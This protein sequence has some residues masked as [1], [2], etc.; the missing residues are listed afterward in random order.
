MLRR[1]YGSF[2]VPGQ[3]RAFSLATGIFEGKTAIITGASGGIGSAI[4]RRLASQGCHIAALGRNVDKVQNMISHLPSSSPS[5]SSLHLALPCDV[6]DSES[7]NKAVA[8]ILE[9]RGRVDFLI[10]AAG[11]NKDSLLLRSRDSDIEATLSTNLLGAI[12]MSRAV[13]KTM[14]QQK[15]GSIV[16]IG[17]V[18]GTGGQIGQ[19]A[20]AASKA[21]LVGLTKSLAKE[22]GSRGIR[23]NCL[24]PGFIETDMT[25]DI[26]AEKRDQLIQRIPLQTFGQP[27]DVASVVAF[28]C[29]EDS[30]YITGQ[31]MGVDGGLS[32]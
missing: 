31:V 5:S 29:S 12:F 20:Y 28:L 22:V 15:Q 19:V 1:V 13:L 11:I 24:A 6:S 16:N 2:S 7:V 26:A 10:N 27:E 9:Q 18:V 3:T 23:V 32:L 8:S 30:R 14:I 4:A 25:K 21:G 17:S